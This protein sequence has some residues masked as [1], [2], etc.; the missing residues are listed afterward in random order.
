MGLKAKFQNQT[1]EVKKLN[2]INKIQKE[3]LK[4]KEVEVDKLNQIL[5]I[6]KENLKKK[7]EEI[8]MLNFH[9]T[10]IRNTRIELTEKE[11][12]LLSK[13]RGQTREVALSKMIMLDQ[14]SKQK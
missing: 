12:N 7:D 3:K 9:C 1:N 10:Y 8:Q 11:R 2:K 4:N 14:K 13:S 6:E 5:N